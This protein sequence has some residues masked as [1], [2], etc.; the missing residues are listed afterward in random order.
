MDQALLIV[1][2]RVSAAPNDKRELVPTAA[3]ISPVVAPQVETILVVRLARR[4]PRARR[5]RGY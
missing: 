1:G 2:E 4:C 5:F 3:V